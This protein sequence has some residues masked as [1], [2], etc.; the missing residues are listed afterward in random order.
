MENNADMI[1][2]APALVV[3]I[4]VAIIVFTISPNRSTQ[5]NMVLVIVW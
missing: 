4:I 5:K 1:I 2:L 3:R